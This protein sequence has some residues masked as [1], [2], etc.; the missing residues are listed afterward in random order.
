MYPEIRDCPSRQ[1]ATT[2]KTSTDFVYNKARCLSSIL[3]LQFLLY[4][5][6]GERLYGVA[7]LYVI[8]VD[9]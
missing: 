4:L 9:K 6:L 8:A 1:S 3:R 2:K 5:Y 7:H